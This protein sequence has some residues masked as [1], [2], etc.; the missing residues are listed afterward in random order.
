MHHFK[1]GADC[2]NTRYAAEI[3][4]RIAWNQLPRLVPQGSRRM[5]VGNQMVEVTKPNIER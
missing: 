4:Y 5:R 1:K 2:I 3:W